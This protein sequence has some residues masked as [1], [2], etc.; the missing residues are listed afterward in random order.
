M[1]SAQQPRGWKTALRGT[2]PR[3]GRIVFHAD[4]FG[5]NSAVTDG[6]V[7]GF[8]HGLITATSL[9]A[10]APDAARA[11]R[12]WQ[13]LQQIHDAGRLPTAA[14]RRALR[15]AECPFE[16]GVHLNLTQGRPLTS[17]YP[18]ELL[19]DQGRFAGIGR[20]FASF[21]RRR[22]HHEPKVFAELAAQIEF[23]RDHGHRPTHL[24]GHQYI[25]LFPGLRPAVRELLARHQIPALRVARER[26]L[27]RSTLLYDFRPSNWCLA[28]VKRFYAGRLQTEASRWGVDLPLVFFGTS[29]AARINL[30]IL[31]RYLNSAAG[32]RLIEIGV[33]PA[34]N[35]SKDS[36]AQDG[37]R[38]TGASTDSLCADGWSDPLA[39]LRPQELGMLTSPLLVELVQ[40]FG[41]S[42]GRLT[43]SHTQQAARAA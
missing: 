17:S 39:A 40:E 10:N 8:Q 6:I 2:A 16:L 43:Q 31:R 24:N 4:D 34:T 32:C 23:V 21:H 29:H 19:D 36:G 25:E 22:P 5:M 38:A 13:R 37:P 7:R 20:L 15:E 30:E 9:L 1:S 35:P 14:I 27:L 42:L 3:G 28:H 18:P 33:H 12:E 26:G 41:L 11:M